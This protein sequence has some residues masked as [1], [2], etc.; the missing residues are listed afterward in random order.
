MVFKFLLFPLQIYWPHNVIW[1]R[2]ASPTWVVSFEE[3]A[4]DPHIGIAT[5]AQYLGLRCDVAGSYRF[6]LALLSLLVFA[7][8]VQRFLFFQS[9]CC[10][11]IPSWGSCL[12]CQRSH[13]SVGHDCS[14]FVNSSRYS[15]LSRECWRAG[16]PLRVLAGTMGT[17]E[18]LQKCLGS[19]REVYWAQLIEESGGTFRR[20]A[21]GGLLE[22]LK[23][24]CL[25]W[26]CRQLAHDIWIFPWVVIWLILELDHKVMV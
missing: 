9:R 3:H 21:P 20:A 13:R 5:G 17:S 16:R 8:S 6:F 2:R 15:D 12:S 25:K 23:Q 7:V 24:V 10:A 11:L 19:K 26:R 14:W 22:F 1:F 4:H 18:S